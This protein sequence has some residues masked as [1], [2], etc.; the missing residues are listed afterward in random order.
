MATEARLSSIEARLTQLQAG[1]VQLQ[2]GQAQLQAGL[3][4]LQAQLQAAVQGLAAQV[5]ALGGVSEQQQR[6]VARRTNAAASDELFAVVPAPGGAAPAAWPHAF[7]RAALRTL[8]APAVDA[9]L[10][11]YAIAAA[12]NLDARR[13]RL[14]D[15]IGAAF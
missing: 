7:N 6:A 10:A 15:H 12:G 1:Q 2:A 3:V 13:K 9:L 8:S 11:E 5:A 4:Q 14:A